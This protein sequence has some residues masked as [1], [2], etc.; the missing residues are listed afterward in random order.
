MEF[1]EF[2]EFLCRVANH[3]YQPESKE[4]HDQSLKSISAALQKLLS[5]LLALVGMQL[6]GL[7]QQLNGI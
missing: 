7:N 5:G 6:V 2:M 4:G 3:L 1:T